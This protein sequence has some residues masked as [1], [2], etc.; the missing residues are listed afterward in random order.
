M[1][2]HF[3]DPIDAFGAYFSAIEPEF[4]T[5]VTLDFDDGGSQSIPLTGFTGGGVSYYGFT[6]SEKRITTVEFNVTND[7]D[8][9]D[10]IGID[11]ITVATGFNPVPVNNV[12][13]LLALVFALLAGGMIAMR[14][15][16]TG[17]HI[18]PPQ[19]RADRS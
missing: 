5:S 8:V 6:D 15:R 2:F 16:A 10:L 9:R 11:D 18:F 7:I 12:L 3:L 17:W 14:K 1:A 4:S 13:G 19:C